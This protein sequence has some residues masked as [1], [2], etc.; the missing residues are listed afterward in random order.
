MKGVIHMMGN[1]KPILKN[2]KVVAY[3]S[4]TLKDWVYEQAKKQGMSIST[5]ICRDLTIQYRD[6]MKRHPED[7]QQKSERE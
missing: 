1:Y 7:G 2:V 6:W 3:M 4:Q 5:F